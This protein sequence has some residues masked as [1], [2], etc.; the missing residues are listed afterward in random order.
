MQQFQTWNMKINGQ[1]EFI[2]I[3]FIPCT[4]DPINHIHQQMHT[5]G[6]QTV[7]KLQKFPRFSIEA[8]TSG[9]H[10]YNGVQAPIHQS[11]KYNAKCYDITKYYNYKIYTM[12]S[13]KLQRYLHYM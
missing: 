3:L 12:L 4:I 6:L 7:H 9:S 1:T 11:G 8:P 5:T 2:L 13:V 10:Q